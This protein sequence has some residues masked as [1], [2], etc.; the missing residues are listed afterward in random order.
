MAMTAWSA[1][2]K[3]FDLRR[4]EGLT[5][6]RR[7]ARVPMSS[8]CCRRGTINMVREDDLTKGWEIIPLRIDVGNVKCAVLAHP[9]KLWRNQY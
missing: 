4:G 3:Q 8:P 6:L 9:A 7:A 5:S 1:R 2:L